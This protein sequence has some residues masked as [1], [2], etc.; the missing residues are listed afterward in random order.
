MAILA[1]FRPH[2][3]HILHRSHIIFK[4]TLKILVSFE[5]DSTTK[6]LL[7]NQTRLQTHFAELC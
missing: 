2:M 1:N 5:S 3:T 4:T 6:L 7:T